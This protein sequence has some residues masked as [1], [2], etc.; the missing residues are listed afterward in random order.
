MTQKPTVTNQNQKK[1]VNS[2]P[3]KTAQKWAKRW[4]NK[5]SSYNKY[6]ELSAF[7]IPSIDLAEVLAEKGSEYVRAYIGVEKIA[8]TTKGEKPTYVEKLMFVATKLNLE[9]GIYEDMIPLA[10]DNDTN[11][12]IGIYDLSRPCPP[13][14]DP[15]SPLEQ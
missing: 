1:T 8:P 3:L 5:E 2:I 4:R 12:E 7:L 10:S 6:N 14:G 9:T 15:T 13:Y 11:E